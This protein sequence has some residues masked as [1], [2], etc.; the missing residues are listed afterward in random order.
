LIELLVVIAIIAILAAILFPVFAQAREKARQ[1]SCMSN[2]KQIATAVLMYAQDY[3]ETFAPSAYLVLPGIVWSVYDLMTPY[4]KNVDILKCP[5]YTPG[6]D[7][8][9]RLAL[10]RVR[11]AG[12]FQFTGYIP[13][14]GLFGDVLC[15]VKPAVTPVTS[16]ASLSRPTDTIMFFDGYMKRGF[17][18][19][20]NFLAWARHSEGVVVNYADGH[21]KWHR[22]NGIPN[23]GTTPAGARARTYYGWRTTE[24]LRNTEA[25]LEAA[26]STLANPYNDLHGV[27]DGAIT[28]SE[29]IARCP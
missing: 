7:W 13:N 15:G 19:Y 11:A 5:S 9:S 2:Q 17:L 3:D 12:T 1:A 18:D 29:D 8:P 25:L 6:V 20:N 27:P 10:L 23:G 4:L 26:A 21:T 28:D 16:M 14:L 24:P 22:W